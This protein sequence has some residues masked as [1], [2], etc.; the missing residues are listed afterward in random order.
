MSVRMRGW[1]QTKNIPHRTADTR[2]PSIYYYTFHT[3][4]VRV[5]RSVLLCLQV[6]NNL[7]S[8]NNV[9]CLTN[10]KPKYFKVLSLITNHNS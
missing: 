3:G 9:K 7:L 1:R 10:K 5:S 4:Y 6:Y 2:L 8:N